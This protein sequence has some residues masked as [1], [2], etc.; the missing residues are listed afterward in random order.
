MSSIFR[1]EWEKKLDNKA[2]YLVVINNKEN[3]ALD[4]KEMIRL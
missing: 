2:I 1:G 4:T 3:L